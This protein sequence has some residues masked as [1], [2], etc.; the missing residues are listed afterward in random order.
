MFDLIVVGGG[1]AGLATAIHGTKRGL[2]VVVLDRRDLPLDKAC[3]EG[4]MPRGVAALSE[5]DVEVPAWGRAPFF[6]IRYI[7]TDEVAEAR[8]RGGRGLGV[9]RTALIEGLVS[10]ARRLGAD[11]RY[12]CAVEGWKREGDRRVVVRTSGG[13]LRGVLLIGADGLHSRIRAQA[14]LAKPSSGPLR[15][16]VRRHFR[17]RPWSDL[18]EVH[19]SDG[20]EAY[21]TPVGPESVGVAVLWGG[22]GS[23]FPQLLERF[24]GLRERLAGIPT[25]SEALGA[26]PLRQEVTRRYADGV[27]LVGDAAGFL[28]PLTGEG[29]ALAFD[30]AGALVETVARAGSLAAYERA[31]RR[32]TRRYYWGTRLL[33]AVALRPM[34]RR[35]LVATLARRPGLFEHFLHLLTGPPRPGIEEVSGPASLA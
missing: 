30:C 21:V 4:L 5:M 13:V 35:R 20:A 19:W 31:Y 16:G 2:S 9:R 27:A 26:G 17:I 12:G 1:P 22:D 3:G 33:L 32:L 11:L 23:R 34:L 10:R 8:F 29:V 15:Y 7:R 28:D 18:V 14:G 6:G 24:P 25:T